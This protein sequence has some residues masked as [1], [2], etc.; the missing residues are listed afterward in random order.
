MELTLNN[1]IV[2]CKKYSHSESITG[3]SYLS[4]T[5]G[6]GDDIIVFL[7]DLSKVFNVCFGDFD[8]DKYFKSE[9][10]ILDCLSWFGLKKSKDRQKLSIEGLFKYMQNNIIEQ[11]SDESS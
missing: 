4:D 11:K 5:I 9:A 6:D 1:L 3:T 10:E 8:F 2:F 7:D